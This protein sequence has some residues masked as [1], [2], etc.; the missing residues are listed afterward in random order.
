MLVLPRVPAVKPVV[1]LVRRPE[2]LMVLLESD[3]TLTRL[4]PTSSGVVVDA[5][6]FV[7]SLLDVA[8]DPA[9]A[10]FISWFLRAWM[11]RWT[12]A[13]DWV[14]VPTR[15]RYCCELHVSIPPRLQK[16]LEYAGSWRWSVA[17][18]RLA[19]IGLA[20]RKKERW[21]GNLQLRFSPAQRHRPFGRL[22]PVAG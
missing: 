7:A 6:V 22:G 18:L 11:V 9:G 13:G 14:K 17:R 2:P 1:E 3:W 15:V 10:R 21:K 16:Q 4:L 20:R 5:T 8:A 12:A 19:S